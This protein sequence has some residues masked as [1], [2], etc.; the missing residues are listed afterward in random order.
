M[1]R[2][3]RYIFREI[4]FP[5]LIALVALTF[6]VF[7]QRSGLL[8]D[9]IL[10]QSPTASDIW[11]AVSAILPTVLTVTLPMA[12]LM[13]ILTGFSRLSSDSEAIAM[14]AAGI[15][16]R[17]ILRPVLLLAIVAWGATMVLS[18]WVAPQ[19][20][21]KLQSL[22]ASLALRYPTLELRPQVFYEKPGW[23]WKLLFMDSQTGD[24]IQ[25]RGILLV[26]TKDPDQPE[27][28]LAES[29][30]VAP[31]NSNRSLQLTLHNSSRHI[32]DL[33][34]SKR[35]EILS[36]PTNTISIDTPA[37]GA[38]P[39]PSVTDTS[40]E[41]LW[42]RRQAATATLE[43]TVEFHRRLAL[44]FAC[45]AFAL[46]GFPLGVSTNRGGRS[47]GLVLSLILMFTYYL[48]LAGGTRITGAGTFSPGLGAWLP[49]IAFGILGMI[50]LARADRKYEHRIIGSLSRGLEWAATR[51]GATRVNRL[52]LSRWAYTLGQ[53]FRLFRLLDAYVLRGF[54]FFFAIVLSVFSSLFI[55]ITLFELLPDI[56]RNKPTNSAVIL[57]FVFLLPQIFF[58]VAPLAV[59]LAIL[60]NLGTLTKTNEVLAV[61]A[62]AV[63]LY[64]LSLPLILVAAL[65]SALVYMMQDHV[66]PW[67]NQKQDEYRNIIKG[68]AP[69]THR[70]PFRK[71]MLGS[72][73]RIYHY[74]FFDADT[75]T[76]ANLSILTVDPATFQ[77]R[78]R[79][80]AKRASW[81]GS[82]WSL[83]DGWALQFSQD[84]SV[85]HSPNQ[86]FERL[87]VFA[88]DAPSYFTREVREADQMSYS[89]LE[90]YVEDL[91]RSGFDVGSLTVDLYRK[92]SFPMVSFIMALIGVPFSFKTGRKG[93]F[94][95][96]GFCLAVGI[97]YWSSFQLFGKLGGINQLSPFIAAWFPNIIFGA[98][99]FWLML[100]VRT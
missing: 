71:L 8:L 67:T 10:R 87:P 3:D 23:P 21:Q 69:Q 34:N 14:R 93:A 31:T 79:L 62:G 30:S 38:P 43:E 75:S 4:L 81:N 60:I 58:W 32:V 47:T 96:I 5:G 49:N 6:I 70:D 36:S 37:P 39:A 28:T 42:K 66:L 94:Y 72:G 2:L 89:E 11:S 50:L 53:R 64:R 41:E 27:F 83:E 92:L 44:P 25:M 51:L 65:L 52:N 7:S 12:L 77:L 95:G 35:Y 16:M 57:Y 61:K 100:R 46:V 9:I 73:N 19:T 88:M 48:A 33:N 59:L 84:H 40:T 78:E 63:S 86:T 45:L 15:P 13:G 80:F 29:G 74:T 98:S 54:Y 22:R 20:S 76:F 26:D 99:G 17:R 85:K 18:I 68:R 91:R 55:V 97:I 82:N 1:R 24:G 56:I 90:V